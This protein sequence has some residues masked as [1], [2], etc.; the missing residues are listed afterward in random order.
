MGSR[1]SAPQKTTASR[2]DPP[3]YKADGSDQQ[4][5]RQTDTHTHTQSDHATPSE[6]LARVYVLRVMLAKMHK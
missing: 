3:F 1:K 5:D 6:A 4:T 2:S